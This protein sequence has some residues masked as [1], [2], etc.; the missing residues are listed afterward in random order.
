MFSPSNGLTKRGLSENPQVFRI[1]RT[2][3]PA[4]AGSQ[5]GS[6]PK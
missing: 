4:A 5:G 2:G 3:F 1:I 6:G